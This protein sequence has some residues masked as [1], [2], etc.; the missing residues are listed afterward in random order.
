MSLQVPWRYL[1]V[2]LLLVRLRLLLSLHL[3]LHLDLHL[4]LHLMRLKAFR[5]G[6]HALNKA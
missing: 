1:R 4:D 3:H 6:F 5:Y 2:S